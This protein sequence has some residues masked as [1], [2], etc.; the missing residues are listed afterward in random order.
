M[1]LFLPSYIPEL[2]CA[3]LLKPCTTT[4]KLKRMGLFNK[5][6]GTQKSEEP[7]IK[8][9]LNDNGIFINE[10]EITDSPQ[11]HLIFLVY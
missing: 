9:E 7:T 1:I 5:L 4:K 11:T 8:I 6:F 3:V 2:F 10:I